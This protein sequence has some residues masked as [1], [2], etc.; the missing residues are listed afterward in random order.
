[1]YALFLF[2]F[3]IIDML[4]ISLVLLEN[5]E[6]SDISTSAIN[7]AKPLFN[8][9]TTNK[10]LTNS[11]IVLSLLFFAFSMILGHISTKQN[12]VNVKTSKFYKF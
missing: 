5:N 8:T 7:Y 6:M 1:M 9:N 11:I 10:I 3:I 2:L 12:T 4:L